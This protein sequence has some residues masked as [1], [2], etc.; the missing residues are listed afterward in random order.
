MDD[1]TRSA[2]ESIRLDWAVTPDDVW[3]PQAPLHVPG[4]HDAALA[5]VLRAF[6]DARRSSGASPLGVAIRGPA[7]SGKTHLLGQIRERV[8]AVGGY[9]FLIK[10]LDGEDFWRSVLVA[11]LEDLTRPTPT[12]ASQLAQL[13]DRLATAA[14]LAADDLAAIAGGAPLTRKSLDAF[15]TGVYRQHPRHRRRSQ[16]VLRALALTESDDFEQQD[17]GTALLLADVD[18]SEDFA[19]WGIQNA[20]LGYQ[21]IVENISRIIA[22]D[23]AAVVAVDQIDTLIATNHADDEADE[24]AVNRVAH[25]LMTLRETMSRTTSVVSC[26]SA[27]WDYLEAHTP[28]SVIDRYRTP[29]RLQRPSSAEFTRALLTKRFAQF[30]ANADF[31][32]PYPTWPVTEEGLASSID[33]T[34]RDVMRTVDR[35]VSTVLRTGDFGELTEFSAASAQADIEVRQSNF[36]PLQIDQLGQ[37]DRRFAEL[38]SAADPRDAFDHRREDAV[39]PPLLAAGL[40]TWIDALSAGGDMYQQDA[41]PGRNPALHARLRRTIDPLTDAEQFWAFR[42]IAASHFRAVQS[43]LDKA[44][45]ASA[46]SV[47]VSSRSLVLLRRDPWPTG[48]KTVKMLHD[49]RNRGAALVNWTAD[50]VKVLMALAA[51]RAERSEFLAEWIVSRKP[52]QQVGFLAGITSAATEVIAPT[53]AVRP[54][55][56]PGGRSIANRL[57]DAATTGG[58]SASA[59]AH[60]F[61][62]GPGTTSGP[63]STGEP[64]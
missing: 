47:D 22:M 20:R 45:I 21:E 44:G 35:Y 10:L 26:V 4:L 33:F 42:A 36:D 5:E 3:E 19:A 25:G 8:Q 50:D 52:A 27:A 39:V 18:D 59:A 7:G 16:H 51:M 9:F 6:D 1:I 13:L 41:R 63:G 28:Q 31:S 48:A 34:P 56:R 64:G 43:R 38:V 14:G 37:L 24:R 61:A 11:L 60:L 23:D 54:S 29:A 58:L 12:H 53:P 46:V 32:P 55:S 17:I 2:L 49:L 30:Y 57:A 62:S 15:V 40:A